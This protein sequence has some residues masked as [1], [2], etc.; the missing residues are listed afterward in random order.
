MLAQLL[1]LAVAGQP[2]WEI[3]PVAAPG[4]EHHLIDSKAANAKVSYHVYL[5]K[6]YKERPDDRFPVLYWLHGS[7]GGAPGIAPLSN[8]F[9]DAMERGKIPPMV[10]VFPNGLP[11]GMWCDSKDGARPVE[12]I[13][14]KE[15]IPEIDG[16]FR[17]IARP[18]GRVLEGFSMG[19]FGAARLGF[20]YPSIFSAVSM[21]G[22]GPLQ[23]DFSQV[24]EG[25]AA[26]DRDRVYQSAFGGDDAFYTAVHPRTLA[27]KG[28]AGLRRTL[29]R[30]AVGED[31]SMAPFN[32]DFHDHLVRL[33][34]AH[35]FR[36]A[37]G[38]GHSA[39]PLL[40]AL[41]DQ[42]WA[43]YRAALGPDI[44]E[45]QVQGERWSCKA[46]GKSIAGVLLRPSGD[47]PFPAVL[48]SHGLGG[49]GQ[50]MARN[51]G[52]EWL[53]RGYV[54]IATDYTHA[55]R[56]TRVDYGNAGSSVENIWRATVCLSILSR[57]PDV[58]SRRIIAYGHSM[59]GFL[60][61]GLAA[62][63]PHRL[64][65][66]IITAGGV[67]V[68]DGKVVPAPSREVAATIRTPFL[69]FH[70]SADTV[71][72]PEASEGLEQALVKAGTRCERHVFE[73]SGHNIPGERAQDVTRLTDAWL[74]KL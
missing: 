20:A 32:R 63:A 62:A 34:V 1:F 13:L 58:D 36:T 61:V 6:A 35:D 14:I 31:D 17:T 56:Q 10:I 74:Q 11:D 28:A 33:N 40:Q 7:G 47:G 29:V 19:G 52:S 4:V 55:G 30:Q 59:G 46:D 44:S 45:L 54:C 68:H 21:L 9:G 15:L 25:Q 39:I 42:N 26:R 65:G 73:G 38:A 67:A 51:R 60:T 27:A 43:F 50:A 22:A 64:Q 16:R 12:T 48:I 53:R 49:T 71:V 37:Q 5:P 24:P 70:G 69:I 18:E 57:L 66:A 2:A 3:D 8:F 41:G 72:R 23:A